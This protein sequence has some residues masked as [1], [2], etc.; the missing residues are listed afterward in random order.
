MADEQHGHKGQ[1][2]EHGGIGEQHVH[3]HAV[4]QQAGEHGRGY[5]RRHGGGVVKAG[6]LAHVAAGAHL[7]HHREG[8]DVDGGPCDTRQSEH[9][10]HEH[11]RTFGAHEGGGGEGGGQH[12]D[13][14]QNG[15]FPA[16]P[17]GDEAHRQIGNDGCRLSDDQ[18]QVIVLVEDIAGVDGIFAG[19]GV[20]A[21]EPQHNGQQQ[22]DQGF[23]LVHRQLPLAG[24]GLLLI[25]QP[26][27]HRLLLHL[28]SPLVLPHRQHEHHQRRQHDGGNDGEIA[29]ITHQGVADG[30]G[31]EHHPA[32]GAHEVDDGI[33]LGAQRL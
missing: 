3:P 19:H 31:G 27:L 14:R 28:G 23:H 30:G 32:G 21:K 8:V 1:R 9:G 13:A 5:L 4:H 7:H 2:R 26:Q 16:H 15:L 29:G 10:V 24:G 33:G 11:G 6:V 20:V 25:L 17:G 12:N 22:E 18:G